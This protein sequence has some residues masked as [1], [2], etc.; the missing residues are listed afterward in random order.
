[1]STGTVSILFGWEVYVMFF[2]RNGRGLMQFWNIRY[3]LLAAV[4][5]ECY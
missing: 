3:S 2:L 1:M 5:V 4:A